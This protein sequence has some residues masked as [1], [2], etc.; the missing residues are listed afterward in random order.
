MTNCLPAEGDN[1]DDDDNNVQTSQDGNGVGDGG[2]GD[3]GA[4]GDGRAGAEGEAN[5]TAPDRDD[6]DQEGQQVRVVDPEY[7]P[8]NYGARKR[9]NKRQ[10]KQDVLQEEIL[11]NLRNSDSVLDAHLGFKLKDEQVDYEIMALVKKIKRN[12]NPM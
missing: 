9:V 2:A 4:G 6:E 12:F 5:N 7:N 8:A 1:D 3:G 11:K 10:A